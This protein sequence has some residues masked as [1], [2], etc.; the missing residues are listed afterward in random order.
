M[1]K[2]VPPGISREYFNFVKHFTSFL[3]VEFH[4]TPQQL[5]Q[6]LVAKLEMEFRA[7]EPQGLLLSPHHVIFYI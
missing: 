1:L 3:L 5:V 6:M 7:P 4:N 2:A